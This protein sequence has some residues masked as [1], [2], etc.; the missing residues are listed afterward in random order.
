MAQA[1]ELAKEVAAER[2]WTTRNSTKYRRGKVMSGYELDQHIDTT[3]KTSFGASFK[4]FSANDWSNIS[5]MWHA[6]NSVAHGGEAIFH[7]KSSGGGGTKVSVDDEVSKLMLKS[8]N[9]LVL[10]LNNLK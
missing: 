6:R 9:K 3:F 8:A 5:N 1:C 2:L 4:D 10:W 7:E